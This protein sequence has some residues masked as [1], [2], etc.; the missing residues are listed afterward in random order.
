[1]IMFKIHVFVLVLDCSCNKSREVGDS[2]KLQPTFAPKV[3][4]IYIYISDYC[5]K[6]VLRD[7]H[8]HN[9]LQG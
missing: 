4:N 6:L 2:Q 1:M 3:K 7:S 9:E 8:L 5:C